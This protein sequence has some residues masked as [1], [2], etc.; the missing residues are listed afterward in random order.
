MLGYIAARTERLHPVHLDHA[1]HHE[2]PGEDRRGLRDAAAPGRRP[3]RP[4]DGPRQHRPGLPVVRQGHPQG[5]RAGRRELR[6]CCAG[7]GAR[8][9]STGRASSARRCRASPR[10]RARWTACRRSSGTARSAA[11][12]SPSR[13]RTTATASSQQHLLAEGA[14]RGD[15][16]ALPPAV[17]ALRARHAPTR[18]SSASAGRC[19]CARTRQDAVRE[20]RPVLRQRPGLR[21]RPV[22]GGVHR[23]DAADRRQPRSRSSSRTLAFRDYVGD[24]QRQLFLMDHAGLPLKTVLEQLDMLGEEVVPVLRKEFEAPRP[25]TC[26]TRRPTRRWSRPARTRHTC[27]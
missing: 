13:P 9:S 17:R 3:G 19:S 26:R 21:A 5:H 4:D 1:D 2:R 12:R 14:H 11:R 20:F 22:A 16:R 24:Y 25:A 27:R 23:A 18:P 8:T 15:G 10:R 7:C 6:R